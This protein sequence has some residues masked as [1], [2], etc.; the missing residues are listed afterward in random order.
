V[1]PVNLYKKTLGFLFPL[2]K[3]LSEKS[4]SKTLKPL[5]ILIFFFGVSLPIQEK[6]GNKSFLFW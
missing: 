4:G 3:K 5:I 6:S 2:L 1:P